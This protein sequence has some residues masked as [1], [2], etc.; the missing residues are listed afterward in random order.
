MS[1]N[2]WKLI[3][4]SVFLLILSVNYIDEFWQIILWGVMFVN[5][6]LVL[7][8]YSCNRPIVL[9]G[10]ISMIL[11]LLMLT[12]R[13]LTFMLAYILST[14]IIVSFLMKT[15][16]LLSLTTLTLAAGIVLSSVHF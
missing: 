5:I 4:L 8:L 3:L 14:S 6:T 16:I 13:T 11:S 1:K 2:F 7:S 10:I 12:N 15:N 9:I